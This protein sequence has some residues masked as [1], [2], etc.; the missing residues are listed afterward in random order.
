MDCF[1]EHFSLRCTFEQFR[2]FENSEKFWVIGG[3]VIKY[4]LHYCICYKRF[5][6]SRVSG[7]FFANCDISDLRHRSIRVKKFYLMVILN[8]SNCAAKKL[9]HFDVWCTR[10]QTGDQVVHESVGIC[11]E[12]ESNREK[13]SNRIF[14]NTVN[15]YEIYWWFA[16][17]VWG[18]SVE[19]LL[20]GGAGLLP[21][22]VMGCVFVNYY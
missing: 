6:S 10:S 2:E 21:S 1:V 9:F 14:I 20:R 11:W 16:W 7:Y 12:I 13:A 22:A 17:P 4:G 15:F 8:I 18:M 19:N 5:N 3:G